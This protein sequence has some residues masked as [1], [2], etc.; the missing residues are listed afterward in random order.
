M[1]VLFFDENSTLSTV[2]KCRII[3]DLQN[4]NMALESRSIKEID[5]GIKKVR[6]NLTIAYGLETGLPGF[7]SKSNSD[8]VS[9]LSRDLDLARKEFGRIGGLKESE[10]ANKIPE[11]K[12]SLE[13]T[14]SILKPYC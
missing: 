13:K 8:Q 9:Q 10:I 11:V 5:M 6:F 7:G 14:E 1:K 12:E 4:L 3:D 2:K